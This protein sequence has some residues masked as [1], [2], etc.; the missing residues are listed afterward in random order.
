M[1]FILD[2]LKK[3]E[4]KRRAQAG[5][6]WGVSVVAESAEKGFVA[7]NGRW[8]I[9]GFSMVTVLAI[10]S[11]VFLGRGMQVTSQANPNPTDL[12]TVELSQNASP[13]GPVGEVHSAQTAPPSEALDASASLSPPSP[14]T[15]L[16]REGQEVQM[17]EAAD[18]HTGLNA[19]ESDNNLVGSPAVSADQTNGGVEVQNENQSGSDLMPVAALEE[20][21]ISAN[22]PTP[23]N[24]PETADTAWQPVAA[25]YL[26][27]WELPLSVRQALPGLNLTIHVFATQPQDRFVLINGVRFKEG[28]DLGSGAVLA[29]SRAE[30]AL[31]DFRDYRFLLTP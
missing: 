20:A 4:A 5:P 1:S 2:A 22:L 16:A 17:A 30:G 19:P 29:E 7:K 18:Q 15:A 25:D 10:A 28:A 3:S 24:P 9:V 31:V 6:E 11:V 23:A 13:A 26:H 27:Q 14:S 21:V 12:S 8:L